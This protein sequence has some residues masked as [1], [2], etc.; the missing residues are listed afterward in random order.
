MAVSE[1][2]R[3]R[4]LTYGAGSLS[5]AELLAILLGTGQGPGKLSAIGLAQLILQTIGKDQNDAIASLQ[6]VTVPELTKI[7]GV[8]TAKATTIVAAVEIG[9]RVF[10]ARPPDR[11]VVSS[12]E[13]AVAALSQDLM[14][15]PQERFAVLLL[16]NQNRIIGR[17][18]LT[19][20]SATETIAHP[21]EI[22][23]E[24]IRSG[25]VKCIVAHNHPSG[26]VSPSAAD[27]QL[28]RQL[29]EGAKVLDIPL[30]DHLILGNG[31]YQSLRE[32]T[33]LWQEFW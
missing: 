14:Y 4:L 6:N 26:N 24:V 19:I 30:L 3:E 1:R 33:N 8:G 5:S 27:L 29:L 22:F 7:H 31:N 15:Q 20:G 28:T 16:D 12:P 25:A 2:P 11:A 21:R 9:K 18:L 13:V 32:T 23:A 17:R 10:L